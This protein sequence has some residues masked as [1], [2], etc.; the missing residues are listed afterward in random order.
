MENK[1]SWF[2]QERLNSILEMISLNGRVTVKELSEEF[3]ISLVTIRKDL[4]QLEQ[5]G[6]VLRT[7]GGAISSDEMSNHVA[8]E[9]R[10]I[11]NR[12]KKIK[13]GEKA[14]S[15]VSSGDIIFIGA[16]TTTVEMCPFLNEIKNLTV[17]TNSIDIAYN[18]GKAPFCNVV[19]FGGGIKKETLSV[20]DSDIEKTFSK[21]QLDMAFFGG[22]GFSPQDGMT[23]VPGVLIQ[24]KK[25]IASRSRINVGLIDS[26]KAGKGSLDTFI[27]AEKLDILITNSDV[28]TDFIESMEKIRTKLILA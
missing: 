14:A 28:K 4:S 2:Q 13:I 17:V 16:S 23:D 27:P 5:E 18:L 1:E 15:L 3:N 6:K 12:D 11:K 25:V 10:K 21:W 20:I 8:F 26:T 19:I 9:K 7:H 24:Q 22:W